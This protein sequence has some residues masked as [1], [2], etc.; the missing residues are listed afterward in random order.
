MQVKESS[1]DGWGARY[2]TKYDF[3]GRVVAK[4]ETHEGPG[5]E[6]HSL[7]TRYSYDDRGRLLSIGR[8]VDGIE[9]ADVN[10]SYDALGHLTGKAFD[11]AMDPDFGTQSFDYD[12]HGWSTGISASYNGN[13]LF[14]ETL[15]YASTQKPGTDARWD[16]N[17][18]EAA[19]TDPDGAHTYAYTYD[20][21]G[22]LTDAKHY[23]GASNTAT[24]AR[25]ERN[26]SYDRNGNIT[27]LTRYDEAGTGTPLSFAFTGNRI[28]ADTYDAMGNL[29][30]NSRNGLEFSYKLA[31]LPESVEGA[32]GASFTHI[33]LLFGINRLRILA[34]SFSRSIPFLQY[35][36]IFA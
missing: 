31:N 4:A 13:D 3:A 12:I 36:S 6:A 1:S 33:Y 16:G 35:F 2:S 15:R 7:L 32:D 26:L 25:T 24:N 27:A 22:R 10:C 30:R 19:F 29:T 21:M 20:G 18:A 11:D 23:A 5:G 8:E 28:A 34:K 17:I 9:L 14:S